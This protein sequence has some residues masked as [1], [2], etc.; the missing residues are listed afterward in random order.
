MY[1]LETITGI[2]RAI[3][4]HETTEH[5]VE[6]A[7]QQFN[8]AWYMYTGFLRQDFGNTH[9]SWE[10]S[11]GAVTNVTHTGMAPY[12]RVQGAT[13]AVSLRYL[14]CAKEYAS[15]QSG[16][17]TAAARKAITDGPIKE[18][19]NGLMDTVRGTGHYLEH[20]PVLSKESPT[21]I[22]AMTEFYSVAMVALH[23]LRRIAPPSLQQPMDIML[24]HC[25]NQMT[26]FD[27]V[28]ILP[29]DL[30]KE[31]Q[32]HVN[33][34]HQFHMGMELGRQGATDGTDNPDRTA[35]SA[36]PLTQSRGGFYRRAPLISS[37][38]PADSQGATVINLKAER[39]KRDVARVASYL[40][41][42]KGTDPATPK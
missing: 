25:D 40:T 32:L 16:E 34:V 41:P 42:G 22:D 28:S 15:L 5:L 2:T 7:S 21:M 38:P 13:R 24:T 3:A 23:E 33:H 30:E 8:T 27:L 10:K 14:S 29:L 9:T 20:H 6:T 26:K 17:Y 39:T 36:Q 37:K 18:Q 35:S 31:V 4:R 19:I 11:A 12:S 1:K